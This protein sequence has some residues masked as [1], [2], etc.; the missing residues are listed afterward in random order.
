MNVCHRH[1]PALCWV[2]APLL[3]WACRSNETTEKPATEPDT[4]EK[5]SGF[6]QDKRRPQALPMGVGALHE[7]AYSMKSGRASFLKAIALD[8]QAKRDKTDPDWR[9]I[10]THCR[11]ALNADPGHLEAHW[12]LGLALARQEQYDEAAHHLSAAVAGD[13][14]RWGQR[15]LALKALS[16]FYD[17]PAGAGY[18]DLVDQYRN[19][20]RA[21]LDRSLLLVGRRGRPWYP[22]SAGDGTLNHRAEIYAY[23]RD[24]ERYLRLSRTNG[25]MAGFAYAPDGNELLYVSYRAVWTPPVVQGE[26]PSE[27]APPREPF[28]RKLSIGT[29]DLDDAVMSEHE[30]DLTGIAELW[31]GY[32]EPT[33]SSRDRARPVFARVRSP[34]DSDVAPSQPPTIRTYELDISRGRA[35]LVDVTGPAIS[36]PSRS[37]PSPQPTSTESR[38]RFTH[39]LLH[40]AYDRMARLGIPVAHVLADWDQRGA[41]G[42]FR[43]EQTQQTVTLPEGVLA[44][45][46]SMTWSPSRARLAF[47]SVT[48]DPCERD[49]VNRQTALYMVESATGRAHQVTASE[50]LRTP[51]WVDDVHIAYADADVVHIVES[52]SGERVLTLKT[53]G[54]LGLASIAGEPFPDSPCSDE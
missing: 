32:G 19:Q 43:L 37:A 52:T 14:L 51:T 50:R 6:N 53:E 20:F 4:V 21:A 40:V 39:P 48:P 24:S 8:K 45:G 18:R 33:G 36:S 7:F 34:R 3:M 41:A 29:I 47:T 13:F 2:I 23:E 15:S 1:Q 38:D 42:S 12:Y 46:H 28:I 5:L 26:P 30:V 9:A 27:R 11:A 44:L 16:S 54:G 10:A 25:S 31:L 35:K 22:R 17:S 49:A